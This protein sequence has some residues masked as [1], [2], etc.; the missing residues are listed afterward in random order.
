MLRYHRMSSILRLTESLFC[1]ALANLGP[2]EYRKLAHA[3]QETEGHTLLPAV[4][5][6]ADRQGNR[7][8]V[9][10]YFLQQSIVS[11][12]TELNDC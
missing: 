5:S 4:H 8:P 2:L 1:A 7:L 11:Q 3:E 10:K 12:Q 6:R 9:M